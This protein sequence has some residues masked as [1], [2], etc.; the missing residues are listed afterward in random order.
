MRPVKVGTIHSSGALLMQLLDKKIEPLHGN[1]T[2]NRKFAIQYMRS[3]GFEIKADTLSEYPQKCNYYLRGEFV[4]WSYENI[5]YLQP[6]LPS[7]VEM[8]ILAQRRKTEIPFDLPCVEVHNRLRDAVNEL[9]NSY[10]SYDELVKKS[11]VQKVREY[12]KYKNIAK[13]NSKEYNKLMKG[14]LGR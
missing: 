4:A 11:R 3:R 14:I 8:G 9:K 2:N 13:E 7:L 6:V 12:F 1:T 5:M 10:D